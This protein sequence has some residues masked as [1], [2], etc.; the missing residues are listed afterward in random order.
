MNLL[1]DNLQH[2]FAEHALAVVEPI[3]VGTE[4]REFMA[5]KDQVVSRDLLRLAR[6]RRQKADVVAK[7]GRQAYETAQAGVQWAVHRFLGRF[8]PVIFVLQRR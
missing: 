2:A 8:V 1:E 6:L 7:Y 3:V 4:W 5:N